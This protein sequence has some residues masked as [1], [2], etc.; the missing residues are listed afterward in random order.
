MERSIPFIL[1]IRQAFFGL[2][3]IALYKIE[4]SKC[5]VILEFTFSINQVSI[6]SIN[7]KSILR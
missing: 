6:F 4:I 3:S 7:L 1:N 2:F 5:D